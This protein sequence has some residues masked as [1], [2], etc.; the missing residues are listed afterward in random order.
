MFKFS[1]SGISNVSA[2]QNYFHV[3]LHLFDSAQMLELII[4]MNFTYAVHSNSGNAV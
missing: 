4:Q 1:D 2:L 3:L